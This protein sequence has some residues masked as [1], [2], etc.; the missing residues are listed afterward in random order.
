MDKADCIFGIGIL[1]TW[2]LKSFSAK[3]PFSDFI[4]LIN[5]IQF[6]NLKNT[7]AV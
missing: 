2:L 7:D 4:N 3:S 6:N 5:T 1:S